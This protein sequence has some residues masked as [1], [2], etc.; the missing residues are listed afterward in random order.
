MNEG[1]RV[2]KV[3]S[4]MG[5]ASRRAAEKLIEEGRVKINGRICVIGQKIDPRKDIISVDG[6]KVVKEYGKNKRRWYVALNK[7]R[8]YVTTM[9]DELGRKCVTELLGDIDERVYP[10]GRLDKNSEGLLLLTNDGEFANL[11]MHPSYHINKTY[12]VTVDA[13]LNEEQLI[14]L[15]S[16]VEIDGKMTLPAIVT[17]LVREPNRAVIQMVISEGRNRQ[18]RKMCEAVGLEVLRLK[19][20]AVGGIRLGM[21]KPGEWRELTAQEVKALR[22]QAGQKAGVRK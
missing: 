20:T 5:F 14:Q 2:Q 19:R 3:L 17:V 12:R 16:G 21:L 18:I 22:N 7:P 6:E 1:V 13:G 4:D 11:M 15:A 8:G 10:V 9:S